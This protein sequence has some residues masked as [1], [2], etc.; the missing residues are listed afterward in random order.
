MGKRL[1][2]SYL[3]LKLLH[4]SDVVTAGEMATANP[5]MFLVVNIQCCSLDSYKLQKQGKICLCFPYKDSNFR[6]RNLLSMQINI[7]VW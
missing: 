1:F 3:T 4:T 7:S 6:E 2:M 5:L